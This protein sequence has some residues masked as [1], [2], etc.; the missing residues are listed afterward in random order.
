MNNY[1][2]YPMLRHASDEDDTYEPYN[3]NTYDISLSDAGTVYGGTLDVLSG[4]LTVDRKFIAVDGSTVKFTFASSNN[5]VAEYKNAIFGIPSADAL[6]S[7]SA[8]A[9]PDMIAN[10]A[11]AISYNAAASKTSESYGVTI[12]DAGVT[13]N[14]RVRVSIPKSQGVITVAD[15]NTWLASHNLQI[16]YPLTSPVS[17]TLT[18]Q[19][20][21]SLVGQNHIWSDAGEVEVTYST[22][23]HITDAYITGVYGDK[24]DK[25]EQ[26]KPGDSGLNLVVNSDNG[27]VMQPDRT[28]TV[29]LTGEVQRDGEDIDPDGEIYAY[30]WWQYKDNSSKPTYL[31]VGKEITLVV[32]GRLCDVT[33]GVFFEIIENTENGIM[34]TTDGKL[35]GGVKKCLVRQVKN[36][37]GTVTKIQYLT[38]RYRF[39]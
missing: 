36:T 39:T 10:R 17:Y 34:L 13:A 1:V 18:P 35:Y 32:N 19:Q 7:A 27:S 15:A 2:I 14:A 33:T 23:A 38:A 22:N 8:S 31:G 3:G 25:G 37:S 9:I 30:R 29:T 21:E 4:E 28:V 6:Q 26:G 5:T 16:V 20:V 24:G 11:T 12:V